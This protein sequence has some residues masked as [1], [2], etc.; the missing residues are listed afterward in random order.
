MQVHQGF[1]N[2]VVLVEDRLQTYQTVVQ[3]Y[4]DGFKDPYTQSTG[5]AFSNTMLLMFKCL[6]SNRFSFIH[7]AHKTLAWFTG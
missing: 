7:L 6:P 1:G 2:I 3:V 4:T 5:F